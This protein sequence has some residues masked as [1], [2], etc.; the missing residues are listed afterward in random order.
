MKN[1]KLKVML[2]SVLTLVLI[3][4]AACGNGDAPAPE[5]GNGNANED[6]GNEVQKIKLALSPFQ[7]VYSIHVGIENGFFEEEGIELEIVET[8]WA[9][10]NDLLVGDQVDLA[11]TSDSDVVLQNANGVDTTLAFPVFYYAGAALMYD[12]EKYDWKTY[13]EFFA[14][15]NDNEEAMRLTLEQV[16]GKKIGL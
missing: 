10:G 12:D 1:S 9:G 4:L 8:D 2:L 11:T 3:V 13:D 15:T 14:E 7:D 6:N 5:E 16:K